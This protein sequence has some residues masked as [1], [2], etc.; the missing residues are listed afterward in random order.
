MSAADPTQQRIMARLFAEALLCKATYYKTAAAEPLG[1]YDG[2]AAKGQEKELDAAADE[3]A[4][5]VVPHVGILTQY[6]QCC[7]DLRV[8]GLAEAANA[9]KPADEQAGDGGARAYVDTVA[10]R[11]AIDEQLVDKIVKAYQPGKAAVMGALD[12][13]VRAAGAVLTKQVHMFVESVGALLVHGTVDAVRSSISEG[14]DTLTVDCAKAFGEALN[15]FQAGGATFIARQLPPGE[16]DKFFH[17]AIVLLF[18]TVLGW[19]L[20][21]KLPRLL[22][23]HLDCTRTDELDNWLRYRIF[24]SAC[25]SLL[26]GNH[27][28]RPRLGG[29]LFE[30]AESFLV[31]QFG[32]APQGATADIAKMHDEIKQLFPS[33]YKPDDVTGMT[34]LDRVRQTRSNQILHASTDFWKAQGPLSNDNDV[35]TLPLKLKPH[36]STEDVEPHKLY[37][38]SALAESVLQTF[39][40]YG[41]WF[42]NVFQPTAASPFAAGVAQSLPEAMLKIGTDWS[43][44]LGVAV[45]GGGVATKAQVQQ[46]LCWREVYSAHALLLQYQAMQTTDYRRADAVGIVVLA[47]VATALWSASDSVFKV[48]D[49]DVTVDGTVLRIRGLDKLVKLRNRF[50]NHPASMLA[51][52]YAKRDGHLSIAEPFDI[53]DYV[54]PD[55]SKTPS[56]CSELELTTGQIDELTADVG[57]LVDAVRKL[58]VPNNANAVPLKPTPTVIVEVLLDRAAVDAGVVI[59]VDGVTNPGRVWKVQRDTDVVFTAKL[60]DVECMLRLDGGVPT[61]RATMRFATS[62]MPYCVELVV[63]SQ[64]PPSPPDD[65]NIPQPAHYDDALEQDMVVVRRGDDGL[66]LRCTRAQAETFVEKNGLQHLYSAEQKEFV[67]PP[68]W[69]EEAQ[70]FLNRK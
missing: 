66:E 1:K 38:I 68:V 53:H 52:D 65:N 41:M 60:N 45:G 22:V 19:K 39:I 54:W 61:D 23:T 8:C 7:A 30:Y 12:A 62:F 16:F 63:V 20:F 26:C 56:A 27:C 3:L 43:A 64:P 40:G 50:F 4:L 67:L 14:F 44:P 18:D 55:G 51:F 24:V 6:L 49:D 58:L 35:Y 46:F 10:G 13:E 21:F 42:D 32:K 34:L 29:Y 9:A 36:A 2:A 11:F 48:T 69:F 25:G 37:A 28:S 33:V 5:L 47:T 17:E 70:R 31:E 59:E 15:Q 57:N